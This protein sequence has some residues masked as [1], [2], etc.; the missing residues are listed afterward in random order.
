MSG[1]EGAGMDRLERLRADVADLREGVAAHPVF[2]ASG[3]SLAGVRLFLEHHVFA[4]WDFMSLLKSLQR[5]VTSCEVPW[6]PRG[7]PR[8]RRFVNEIVLA[9]E[10]DRVGDRVGSH[11]E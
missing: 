8:T 4:V 3:A 11:L 6:L 7:N 2:A 9:E 10:S 1:A 5:A